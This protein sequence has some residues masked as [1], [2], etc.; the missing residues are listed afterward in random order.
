MAQDKTQ[1]IVGFGRSGLQ[2]DRV[3]VGLDGAIEIVA[4]L[5]RLAQVQVGW[6]EVGV[7]SDR[8]LE[9]LHGVIKLAG[10]HQG[11]AKGIVDRCPLRP[12][13]HDQTKLADGGCPVPFLERRHAQVVVSLEG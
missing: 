6:R 9:L 1:C 7:Q 4:A 2:S 8:P 10:L 5:K 11:R 3:L 12:S 13:L